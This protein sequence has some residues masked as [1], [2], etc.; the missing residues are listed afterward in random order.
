MS[1]ELPEGFKRITFFN[2]Y[3]INKEGVV[4]NFVSGKILKV[5]D[6]GY[7]N[8]V[9]DKGTHTTRRIKT[10]IEKTFGGDKD[11]NL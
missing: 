8:M 11:A 3:I 1:D 6:R 2:N 10:I 9:T 5:K 4:I 7:V